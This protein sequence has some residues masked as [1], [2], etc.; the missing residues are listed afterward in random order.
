MKLH[1]LLGRAT[2]IVNLDPLEGT[3][4]MFMGHNVYRSGIESNGRFKYEELLYA[5]SSTIL[6]MDMFTETPVCFER[7]I[8]VGYAEYSLGLFSKKTS[9]LMNFRDFLDLFLI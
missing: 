8:I 3:K 1:N 7:A 2:R 6:H 9:D 4:A 5:F